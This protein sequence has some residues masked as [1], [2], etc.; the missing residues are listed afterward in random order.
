[1]LWRIGGFAN[2]LGSITAT[3][4]RDPAGAVKRGARWWRLAG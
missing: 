2:S 3:P 1:M 4:E